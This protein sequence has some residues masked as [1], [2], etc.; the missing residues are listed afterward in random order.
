MESRK[1]KLHFGILSTASIVPRLIQAVQELSGVT[2]DAIASRNSEKAKSW[3]EKWD[4]PKYYGS[5]EDLLA[6]PEIDAVYVAMLNSK[7]YEYSKKALEAGKHVLCEK[8]FTLLAK[9]AKELFDL[10]KEKGLFLMEAQKSVFLPVN[11]RVKELLEEGKIGEVY[12]ADFSS[13]FLATYDDWM[14]E[15][16]QGGGPL[17]CS[18]CYMVHLAR[19]LLGEPVTGANALCTMGQSRVDEQCSVNLSIANKILVNTRITTKVNTDHRAILYGTKGQIEIPSYWKARKAI[20]ILEDGTK[21]VLD[22]PCEHELQY[23]VAHFCQCVSQKL[24]ESPVMTREMTVSTVKIV[25]TL[26][27]NNILKD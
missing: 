16:A 26:R 15:P 18:T 8:P 13:S 14:G 25:E 5:Y 21:E 1:E 4:I 2:V 6:D 11:V 12:L 3:A 9:E 7:H 23:E 22:Y 10:A 20:V 24:T 17:T 19:F 27:K